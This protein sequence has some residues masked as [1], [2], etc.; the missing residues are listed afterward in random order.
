MVGVGQLS[1]LSALF[2]RSE[3]RMNK[4]GLYSQDPQ[5]RHEEG[6]GTLGSFESQ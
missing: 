1:S 4:A 6:M 2:F 3:C 5:E